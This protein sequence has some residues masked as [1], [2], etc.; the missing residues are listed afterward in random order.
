MSIYLIKRGIIIRKKIIMSF[1]F[2]IYVSIISFTPSVSIAQVED[3]LMQEIYN[4]FDNL[5]LQNIELVLDDVEVPDSVK[6]IKFENIEEFEE[7]LKK[8]D[9]HV[10]ESNDNIVTEV[11]IHHL[12]EG[13]WVKITKAEYDSIVNDSNIYKNNSIDTDF[14][15]YFLETY[16]IYNYNSTPTRGRLLSDISYGIERTQPRA[17]FIRSHDIYPS[18][19]HAGFFKDMNQTARVVGDND[20]RIVVEYSFKFYS[21][22]IVAE[23]EI[24]T[25][26][27]REHLNGYTVD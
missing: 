2:L 12:K 23:Q 11:T 6:P 17:K 10:T 21:K 22:I 24:T 4:V 25:L 8:L 9:K 7:Y 18:I 19:E 5:N 16:R 15:D 26:V 27:H 1:L 20:S 13:E 14:A 3:N